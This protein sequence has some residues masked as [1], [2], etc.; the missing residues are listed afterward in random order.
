MRVPIE[1]I[2]EFVDFCLSPEELS[3][4]LTMA[5]LEVELIERIN[6]DTV[7]E[8]NVTPNRPDCLSM[9]GIAREIS[10]LTGLPLKLPE[11]DIKGDIEDC[12]IKVEITGK[13]LCY[14]YA[15]RVI[16]DVK[17]GE[18][19]E[20]IKKRLEKCGMRSI[21]NIVDIT[22]YVL[23]E[24]GHPLHAF[25]MDELKGKTVRVGRSH[26]ISTI[27]TLDGIERRLPDD[28]LLIWDSEEPVAIAGIMGGIETEVKETTR[29]IFLE[30]AY[31]LP[32]S[33]RKTSKTLGLKTESAYRFERGTDIEFLDKAL[34]RASILISQIAGGRVSKKTDVYPVKTDAPKIKVRPQKINGII[35]ILLSEDEITGILQRIGITV[36]IKSG[37][38]IAVPPSFRSD[39][40]REIDIIEEVARFYG[41]DRVPV[42]IP[43]TPL[44]K[45]FTDKRYHQISAI[46]ESLRKSGFTEAINYSFM[47]YS[48]LDLLKLD[49]DDIRRRTV[50]L[51]NPINAEESHLRTTIMPALI[52]NLAYNV[53]MGSRDFGLF[54]TS[55]VFINK[56]ET[57]PEERHH[58]GAIYLKE[59]SPALWKEETPD[60]YIMKGV[61]EHLMDEILICDFSFKPSSEP[62]LH[63]GKSC[64]ILVSGEKT[65]FI[66]V[67]HPDITNKLS[68]KLSGSEILLIEIDL[69]RLL[70]SIPET[71]RFV[72][73]P[74]Y[75]HIERDIA[76]IVDESLPASAVIDIIKTYQ[77]GLIEG[78]SIFDFYKGKNIPQGKKSL[79]FSVRYRAEDR[80]LTDSEIEDLHA[81]L[82][83]FVSS[84]SGGTIRGR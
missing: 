17:T 18:S 75:P 81:S 66:G 76:I 11:H 80:T 41:Y 38:L 24:M 71:P 49:K 1:W 57:L 83:S 59:K 61:V 40:Q 13:D 54:E 64:D 5:G 30:S 7:I 55:R 22:N 53:S 73:L 23:L 39:I 47:N 56:G 65:G 45:D 72:P 42:T 52:Q 58:L 60:F 27:T 21:S 69:D 28:A 19:P 31:F 67:L 33:V 25:D 74:K 3:M 62:F 78:V 63:P 26:D 51:R 6:G 15:G 34:D 9:L 35:G 68:L 44:T 84:K 79:A 29:N 4:K 36:E 82:V 8:V 14:R 43:K 50:A 32:S 20:W 16:K 37:F 70:L 2:R 10:A 77:S 12:D 46:K 48:M